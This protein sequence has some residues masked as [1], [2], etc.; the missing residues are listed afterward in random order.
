MVTTRYTEVYEK[1][2]SRG[3]LLFR[4]RENE[5]RDASGALVAT[6]RCGHV[7]GFKGLERAVVV[8]AVNGFRDAARARNLLYTGLSRARLQ[9]V[10]VGPRDEIEGVGGEAVRRRMREAGLRV[11]VVDL[12]TLP[13]PPANG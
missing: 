10:V 9:L 11:R 4:V 3:T 13:E 5:I 7:L 1:Q 2:G 12:F 8:L 6:S